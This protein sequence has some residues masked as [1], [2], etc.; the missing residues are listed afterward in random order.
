MPQNKVAQHPGVQVRRVQVHDCREA[1]QESVVQETRYWVLSGEEA[2]RDTRGED[3]TFGSE[4]TEFWGFHQLYG[5]G[6]YRIRDLEVIPVL[7]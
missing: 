5:G 1:G 2:G 7:L 3:Q 6:S 4:R